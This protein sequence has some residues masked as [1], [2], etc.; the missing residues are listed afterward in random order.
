MKPINA[1]EIRSAYTKFILNFAF[2]T[3]FSILCI[4][5]FFAASDYEYALLDKKVKETE[6]LSYL[7]KDIN[8]NFDLI[9]VRFKE[10]ALYR[11]YNANEMS[12]QSI[13]LNDIQSANNKIKELISK[14]TENS[15]SFDLYA[16]LNNNVGAMAD[17]QDSLIKSRGD[18]QR[19]KE[20]INDCQRINQAAAKKI[21]NGQF[22]R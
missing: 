15:P 12:K 2:L 13:L 9:Q 10:L 18:I 8:T 17:L 6:K 4:Y 11:D 19:Y 21:R 20:Q 7:R 14:K 1:I 16:K 22:G 3:I 5:L